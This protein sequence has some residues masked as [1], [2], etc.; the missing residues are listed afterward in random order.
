MIYLEAHDKIKK[1]KAIFWDIVNLMSVYDAKCEIIPE[2]L[3]TAYNMA[4]TIIN[5]MERQY[6]DIKKKLCVVVYK[7]CAFY[8]KMETI[9]IINEIV[10]ISNHS[11]IFLQLY[12]LL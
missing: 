10:C 11:D 3:Y 12:L 1:K 9:K 7:F 5:E 2:K 4:G 6:T 8:G